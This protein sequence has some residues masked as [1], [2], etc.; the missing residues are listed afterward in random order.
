MNI[1]R[2]KET[3]FCLLLLLENTVCKEVCLLYDEN[4]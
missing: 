1:Q 4:L 2:C 3:F